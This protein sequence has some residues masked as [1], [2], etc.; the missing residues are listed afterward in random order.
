ML[1]MCS[2][3][4]R[5]FQIK[6]LTQIQ[7]AQL[8]D[9]AFFSPVVIQP[10]KLFAPVKN[11]H[12]PEHFIFQTSS[13][14]RVWKGF[15]NGPIT[16]S[17]K[18]SCYSGVARK[19][20]CKTR[21]EARCFHGGLFLCP[22]HATCPACTVS[23]IARLKKAAL[24]VG[25]SLGFRSPQAEL[26]HQWQSSHRYHIGQVRLPPLCQS[27]KRKNICRLPNEPSPPCASEG[28]AHVQA[29]QSPTGVRDRLALEALGG[30]FGFSDLCSGVL[31]TRRMRLADT[32]LQYTVPK[33][34]VARIP[35][36][37]QCARWVAQRL[38]ARNTPFKS[39]L[40]S[41][42]LY[43]RL[44]VRGLISAA[45]LFRWHFFRRATTHSSQSSF[46]RSV[47]P[48]PKAL[49]SFNAAVCVDSRRKGNLTPTFYI[50]RWRSNDGQERCH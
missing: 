11:G 35:K 44:R 47:P 27:N 41:T 48:P 45:V 50:S 4:E 22:E 8:F 34:I 29:S 23:G 19:A 26:D 20:I 10:I 31:I 32:P 13:Q 25:P 24:P 43:A 36:R 38:S 30:P 16:N 39:E 6:F 3:V 40:F 12:L 18:E 21:R 9:A 1:V 28:K 49:C 46:S 15:D 17:W 7:A 33:L 14:E 2:T 5:L 42:S 37:L